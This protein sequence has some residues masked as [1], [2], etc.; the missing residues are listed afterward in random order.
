MR[1]LSAAALLKIANNI[2]NEPITII[3]VEWV[4][5]SDIKISYADRD[6]D[7]IL[8]RIIEVASLDNV[9]NISNNSESQEIS[10]I[11]D[12]TNGSIKGIMDTNDVHLRNV[13]VYQWFEGLDLS[14]KFLL[15][16]GKINSP[17]S[18]NEGDRTV[19]FTIISQ[20]EDRE[21]GFSP[22]EG[23]FTDLTPDLIG[24]PWPMCFGTVL[25]V[26][27]LRL[28][29]SR[30]G[31]LG[32]GIGI[33]DF[34]LPDRA[35]AL[36]VIAGYSDGSSE[37]SDSCYG[38]YLC[39][40]ETERNSFRVFNSAI[41]PRGIINLKIGNTTLEGYF[42]GNTNVFS[43]T[44][45]GSRYKEN[46]PEWPLFKRY[47]NFAAGSYS[48]WTG[49]SESRLVH[50]DC[51]GGTTHSVFNPYV[52]L[53]HGFQYQCGGDC[54]RKTK[55]FP[56]VE[57]TSP[58]YGP[59]GY[60]NKY[61]AIRFASGK[62]NGDNAGYIYLQPGSKVELAESEP[63]KFV[64][65]I[66]PGTVIKVT[67]WAQREGQKFLQDVPKDYYTV[68]SETWGDITAVIVTLDEALSKYVDMGWEDDIYVTFESSV[69]PNVVDIL[70]YLIDLYTD[71]NID[72]V[73]FAH[74]KS[75]VGVYEAHFALYN[76]KE[77]LT[78]LQEI[79]YQACC[80]IH[81]KNDV[82]YIQYLPEQPA[83]IAAITRGDII[84]E[85]LELGHTD[86][87]DIITKMVC[88]WKQSDAQK[89]PFTTILRHNVAKYGTHEEEFNYYI[90]NYADAVIKSAT[91]W[92]IRRANTWKKVRF[93]APLTKLNLESLDHIDINLVGDLAN[94]SVHCIIETAQ[95]DSADHSLIFECWT[96]VKA[97]TMEPYYFAYP[98]DVDQYETFPTDWE[99][100][101]G[102]N[103]SGFTPNQS[104][105]GQL[106][107]PLYLLR[108]IGS[109]G[110][111]N[112]GGCTTATDFA[113][114]ANCNR[115]EREEDQEENDVS[116]KNI[117]KGKRTPSDIG[118]VMPQRVFPTEENLGPVQQGPESEALSG[119]PLIDPDGY[120]NDYPEGPGSSL[121]NDDIGNADGSS[122][123]DP[124]ELPD[125]DELPPG[126][127][128]F[129]VRVHYLDPVTH[130]RV[131]GCSGYAYEEGWDSGCG[132]PVNGN[133]IPNAEMYVFNSCSAAQAFA[134]AINVMNYGCVGSKCMFGAS[135]GKYSGGACTGLVSC[136]TDTC[137]E[138]E[139]PQMT[140]FRGYSGGTDYATF[141]SWANENGQP[142]GS[143]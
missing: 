27:A 141:S 52:P 97:G 84:V 96:P 15:F 37:Q 82:F 80:S 10:V 114:R 94:V 120:G 128:H 43:L 74:V 138:P 81:L 83:S 58:Y 110:G 57:G 111:S 112:T 108:R 64:V 7:G 31:I 8:G 6:L 20:L 16:K 125:P 68:S 50:E 118:D 34:A 11:L 129:C 104:A 70:E 140:A 13:W 88:K 54:I 21:I 48:G 135:V 92:M 91:F 106:V 56:W 102:F 75:R 51:S 40:K 87:E 22:E 65:S 44:K 18:W 23:Q 77:I 19:R 26:K 107:D 126:P 119:E 35:K 76:R 90:Y 4:R 39:Q 1:T 117:D 72:A 134:D 109:S 142:D 47:I 3:E 143:P 95:Y 71:F 41:F 131:S 127:C 42:V 45:T 73:S 61:S 25:H 29:E 113:F 103:G 85:T 99:I 66:V 78:V 86:T 60:D 89:E 2:G 136:A 130:V 105:V 116:D 30:S 124:S 139:D 79:S 14:D 133:Y 62:V 28:T 9:V 59:A 5:N 132:C 63:Q 33:S 67:A 53:L 123:F 101:E 69:G 121:G 17:V 46:H 55:F 93:K 38:T 12:D 115:P 100:Q 36:A 24:Q 137:T 122:N 49:E 98:A 32:D